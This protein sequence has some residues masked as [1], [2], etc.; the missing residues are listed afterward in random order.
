MKPKRLM[1]QVKIVDP[2]SDY[3]EQLGHKFAVKIDEEEVLVYFPVTKTKGNVQVFKWSQ[4]ER[5]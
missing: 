1:E 2:K 5:V 3:Y 4:C